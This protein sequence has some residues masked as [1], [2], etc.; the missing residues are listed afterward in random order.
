MP[1]SLIFFAKTDAYLGSL[2]DADLERELDLTAMGFGKLSLGA[3]L[4]TAVLANTFAHTGEI[5][6]LKGIQGSKGYPF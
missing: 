4:G 2:T 5:S 3:L 1:A 6:A